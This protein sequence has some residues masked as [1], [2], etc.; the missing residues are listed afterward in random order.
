MEWDLGMHMERKSQGW[1]R[2]PSN[3]ERRRY[4]QDSRQREEDRGKWAEETG[5]QL[6]K[7]KRKPR[8]D[9][10]TNLRQRKGLGSRLKEKE[11]KAKPPGNGSQPYTE[12]LNVYEAMFLYITIY[13]TNISTIYRI[14]RNCHISLRGWKARCIEPFAQVLSQDETVKFIFLNMM[15]CNKS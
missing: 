7:S 14:Y 8:S 11:V 9:S 5:N 10:K 12:L 6:T 4:R 15:L 13:I 3:R 2:R 1:A